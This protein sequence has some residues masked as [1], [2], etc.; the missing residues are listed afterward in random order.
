MG[1]IAPVQKGSEIK[2]HVDANGFIFP[3][4][5]RLEVAVAFHC[6]DGLFH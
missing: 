4:L 2:L 5:L 6:M 1:A 3:F